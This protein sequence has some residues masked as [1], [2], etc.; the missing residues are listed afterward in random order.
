L[1]GHQKSIKRLFDTLRPPKLVDKFLLLDFHSHYR[2]PKLIDLIPK[3][4]DLGTVCPVYNTPSGPHYKKKNQKTSKPM[5]S[6]ISVTFWIF[7]QIYPHKMC[8]TLNTPTNI[9]KTNV[10]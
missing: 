5:L 4:R 8:E 9:K 6:L 2:S 10:E 1:I 7:L 3:F